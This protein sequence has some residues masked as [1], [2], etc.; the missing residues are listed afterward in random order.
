MGVNSFSGNLSRIKLVSFKY[1]GTAIIFSVFL[2]PFTL[3]SWKC[4]KGIIIHS[5]KLYQLQL[6]KHPLSIMFF[7]SEYL[8]LELAQERKI[9]SYFQPQ[10]HY[11][12]IQLL[13]KIIYKQQNNN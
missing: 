9:K 2:K 5:L 8:S 1:W 13:N 6:N 3:N 4:G 10:F 12:Q 11:L 7:Y